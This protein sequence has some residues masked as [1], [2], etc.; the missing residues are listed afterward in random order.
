EE[1]DDRRHL[2]NGHDAVVRVARVAEVVADSPEQLVVI[3]RR[4]D[5]AAQVAEVFD[6]QVAGAVLAD[7]EVV[8]A[9]VNAAEDPRKPGD[10]QVVLGDVGPD[11]LAGQG[12]GGEALEVLRGPEGAPRQELAR[13]RIEPRLGRHGGRSIARGATV[14]RIAGRARV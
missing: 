8:A 9:R 7:L 3:G 2:R 11:L 6:Q 10:Q 12:A 5:A 4:A 13:Q 14:A 1:G